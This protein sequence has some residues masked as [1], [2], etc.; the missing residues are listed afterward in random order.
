LVGRTVGMHPV[1]VIIAL[2]I[3]IEAGGVLGILISVPAAVVFQEI[4][5]DWGSRKKPREVAIV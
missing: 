1:I 2:L 5:E 3:G 4:I